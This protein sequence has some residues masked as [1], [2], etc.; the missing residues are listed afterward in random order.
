MGIQPEEILDIMENNDFKHACF[1]SYRNGKRVGDLPKDD[2]LN[3]F[4][5][6]IY[7]ALE[8][9]L[10]AY[11]DFDNNV[12]LD[13]RCLQP[14]QF[15]IPVFSEAICHSV[16]YIVI[17]TP[18]YLSKNKM[19]CAS[20]LKSMI[21]IEQKRLKL[22]GR[23][24]ETGLIITLVLRGSDYLPEYLK[25]RVWIDFSPYNLSSEEIK[26]HPSFSAEIQQ[27]AEKIYK[28]HEVIKPALSQNG[29]TLPSECEDF[30]IAD[31]EDEAEREEVKS[32]IN[33]MES[34]MVPQP[35]PQM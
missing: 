35:F 30:K 23:G 20:E 21:E 18:N 32:F 15:L 34:G 27:L 4:A 17:Y 26:K 33:E 19:F 13:I 11:F 28:L 8:S 9:E 14:G 24:N 6:Q 2:L 31:I 29:L 22:F 3:T 5:K 16:A 1:I 10:H 25:Q 12:F 7:E